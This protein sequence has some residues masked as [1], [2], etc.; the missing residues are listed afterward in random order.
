VMSPRRAPTPLMLPRHRLSSLLFPQSSPRPATLCRGVARQRFPL[1]VSPLLH[2]LPLHRRHLLLSL[3]LR[4][5]RPPP[6]HLYP[7]LHRNDPH[8][9]QP[10]C[11]PRRILSTHRA[12][13]AQPCAAVLS[14][15]SSLSSCIHLKSNRITNRLGPCLLLRLKLRFG[16]RVSRSR[17][18]ILVRFALNSSPSRSNRQPSLEAEPELREH[19]GPQLLAPSAPQSPSVQAPPPEDLSLT[20]R[21]TKKPRSTR[22][23]PPPTAPPPL[24]HP[25]T[26][27]HRCRKS[28]ASKSCLHP[29]WSANFSSR[30][31]TLQN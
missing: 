6:P 9:I 29:I 13:P 23:A 2:F 11:L 12:W 8:T 1:R 31:A 7:Q 10:L 20:S 19:R 27:P 17:R 18:L 30:L 15:I 28:C 14:P 3:L 25:R 16:V 24:L 21:A 5:R 26:L 22:P 4:R